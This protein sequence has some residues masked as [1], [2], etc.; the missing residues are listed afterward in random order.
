VFRQPYEE[1]R[2]PF[3]PMNIHC[4]YGR[5]YDSNI[6]L[7]EGENPTIIDTGTGQF[8]SSV[9]KQLATI[10][11]PSIIQQIVITHEHFDHCGGISRLKEA[12]GPQVQVFTHRFA[13]QK[14]E[15][16]ESD[17]ALMLGCTLT[18]TAVDTKFIG[19]EKIIIGNEEYSVMY[20]PGH[21]PGSICL[22]GPKS[23]TLFSG[24]TVFAYGSFGRTDFPGGS[25]QQLIESI[26]TLSTYDVQKL[27]PGH[28]SIIEGD[29]NNHIKMSLTNIQQMV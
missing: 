3:F 25:T 18:K 22:Y 12:I 11:D 10:M 29:A 6:Y 28:E 13:A 19:G 21:S 1:I 17:F 15:S 14:I 16:G 23:K 5:Q 8:H 20:T 9:L 27:Y 2:H 24:D 26:R 7:I 4:L